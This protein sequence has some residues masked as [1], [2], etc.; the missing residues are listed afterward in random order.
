MAPMP[1]ESEPARAISPAHGTSVDGSRGPAEHPDVVQ[2]RRWMI[3]AVLCLSAFLA[4]VD[5]TI[6]NVALPTI[7]K[8]LHASTSELQW[9]VD[10]YSLVFASLLLA[11]GSLGDR[12]G[13]K[14]ALQFGLV[15]F[16]GFS[17]MAGLSSSIGVLVVARSL[18]GMAAAMIYPAT[19]AILSNTF[20]D[21]RERTAAVGVWAGVSG[22]AVALGPVTGGALLEHFSWGSVFFVSIPIA[23]LA[24]GLGAWLIPT[25]RDPSAPRLDVVGTGLSI[26][27]VGALVYTTIE[28]PHHGWLSAFTLT[29]Y[30]AALAALTAFV[31]WERRTAEPMLDISL[32]GD[33]R[34]SAASCSITVA[35]FA[36]FGFIFLI[37]QYFQLIRGYTPLSAGL[38]TLPFAFGVGAAAPLSPIVVRRFGTK[39]VVPS[40]LLLMAAGFVIASTIDGRTAYFGRVMVS[41]VLMAV[42]LALTST[43]STDA[44][45]AVLPPAKAGVGSAVNDVTREL[46]G[47]FGVAV[48][49]AVFSSIYG[50]D[51]TRLLH[52]VLPTH[53]LAIATS[54]PAAALHVVSRANSIVQPSIVD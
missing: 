13:R 54:S 35:F 21:A 45:L 18:M 19:L 1:I 6:V 38:H 49:G 50:P 14:G 33:V 2:R 10:G 36:L 42:G 27:G 11:G 23:A 43:P 29:G 53:A 20:T 34:F 8:R 31:V 47:T 25:S 4:V 44:I 40:G 28:A 12:H 52:R 51:L 9:I 7:S 32:F 24:L 48:V 26:V 30:G 22:L 41:M 16:A 46:G 39:L 17:A 37:T 3:L 5:N 15:A